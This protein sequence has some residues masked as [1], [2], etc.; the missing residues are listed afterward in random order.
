MFSTDGPVAH[1]LL[2][3]CVRNMYTNF[4]QPSA[5]ARGQLRK[6][7]RWGAVTVRELL[8]TM[9]KG[10]RRSPDAQRTRA[11]KPMMIRAPES[12]ARLKEGRCGRALVRRSAKARPATQQCRSHRR[13]HTLARQTPSSLAL[14]Q[15]R[16]HGP[17]LTQEA[18]AALQAMMLVKKIDIAPSSSACQVC[19]ELAFR[20]RG[21]GGGAG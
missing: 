7:L 16:R 8:P 5:S 14:A 12:P 20:K 3:P 2:T 15:A 19:A 10:S 11:A 4:G 21:T 18:S 13:R 9:A 1:Q 17:L 6:S